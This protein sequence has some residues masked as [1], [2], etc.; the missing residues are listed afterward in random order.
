MPPK[1]KA[2]PPEEVPFAAKDDLGTEGVEFE[3]IALP[4]MRRKVRVRYLTTPEVTRLGFLPDLVGYM[5]LVEQFT[6]PK[7]AMN[8][9]LADLA[10][11]EKNYQA[12]LA[13]VA[14]MDP[15]AGTDPVPCEACGIDH[16]PALWS[17][18][19]TS[20]M[21]GTDLEE[22]GKVACRAQL[23][24]FLRP[25]SKAETPPD[26]LLPADIGESIPAAS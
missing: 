5:N 21:H 15:D 24:G 11:E 25:F 13:H 8:V 26:T 17:F 12:A 19:Q 1:A 22:I 23:M 16:P 20:R 6:D 2:K 3:D 7:T 4:M 14:I 18:R 10:R 9:D